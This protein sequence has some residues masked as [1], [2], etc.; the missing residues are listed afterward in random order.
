MPASRVRAVAIASLVLLSLLFWKLRI[1]DTGVS[2]MLTFYSADLYTQHSP[3]TEY[4]V[5]AVRQGRLPLWNPYQLCGEPFLAIP[6]VGV[7]YPINL[8]YLFLSVPAGIEA[9]TII[10]LVIGLLG[11]WAL[12]RHFSVSHLAAVTSRATRSARP[13][14]SPRTSR[15]ASRFRSRAM[16]RGCWS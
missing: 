2:Q 1:L 3:M 15:S 13:P 14:R 9:D 11:M 6:Y 10:H 4:A 12:M 16:V 8:L 5:S 7:F